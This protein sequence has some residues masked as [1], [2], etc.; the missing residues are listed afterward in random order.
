M[1][2]LIVVMGV[3]GS[4]KT[5]VGRWLGNAVG[6]EF[7]DGDD[8]HPPENITRMKNGEQLDDAARQPWLAAIVRRAEIAITKGDSL[9][10]ACSALKLSYRDQ[11][12][13]IAAPVYFIFLEGSQLLIE[14][15]LENRVGHFMPSKLLQSQF[16]DLQRPNGEKGVVSVDIDQSA[17][18][19]CREVLECL[20]K[21]IVE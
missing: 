16:E 18:T 2:Y 8:L 12:R 20:Q 11:L 4:G 17:E 13:S 5:H 3:S 9:V 15:R 19:V 21:L 1:A 7:V 14:T 10:V 6:H